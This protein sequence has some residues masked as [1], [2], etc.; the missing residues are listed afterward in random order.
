MV[1]TINTTLLH[2]VTPCSLVYFFLL[3]WRS[4]YFSVKLREVHT[5]LHGVTLQVTGI[6]QI[7]ISRFFIFCEIRLNKA[8][9]NRD[10]L[11][12]IYNPDLHSRSE[13]FHTIMCP[14]ITHWDT[15]WV[16]RH[17]ASV[18]SVLAALCYCKSPAIARVFENPTPLTTISPRHARN[19]T[20]ILTSEYGDLTFKTSNVPHAAG[21]SRCLSSEYWWGPTSVLR[22]LAVFLSL[23]TNLVCGW[24]TPDFLRFCHSATPEFR[25]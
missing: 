10:G 11:L 20:F 15:H 9:Q 24:V 23:P 8:R 6:L 3:T 2:C 18:S 16:L 5:R 25:C 1:V 13:V 7:W 12:E 17:R 14:V 21:A 22:V 4:K 19:F